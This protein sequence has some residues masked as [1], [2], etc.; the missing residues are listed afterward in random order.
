M[1]RRLIHVLLAFSALTVAACGGTAD[2]SSGGGGA[3]SLVAYSTPKE[4]YEEIVP[5]FAKTPE[6]EGTRVK[7]SHGNSGDQAKA[8][9]AGL[10]A[11]VVALSLQPDIQNQA[12]EQ[13]LEPGQIVWL[14]PHRV[15]EFVVA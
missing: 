3:L 10:P 6:G 9:I 8:V 4:A 14:R 13:E 11:D 15:H 7:Q 1:T 5:A 12:A 2:A